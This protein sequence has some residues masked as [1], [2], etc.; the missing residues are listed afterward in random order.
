MTEM[1]VA[2]ND[3]E[4][5]DL[6]IEGKTIV[7][8]TWIRIVDVQIE[9]D[10][11]EIAKA[12]NI[13]KE[14]VR[15]KM[16]DDREMTDV[17]EM[18]DDREMIVV[19]LMID[20]RWIMS[21]MIG[22]MT[23]AADGCLLQ[24][25]V[26]SIAITVV[27]GEIVGVLKMTIGDHQ[28]RDVEI[29]QTVE[30]I[31]DLERNKIREVQMRVMAGPNP[32]DA[33][34]DDLRVVLLAMSRRISDIIRM[35]PVVVDNRMCR[36]V[37]PQMRSEICVHRDQMLT[38]WRIVSTMDHDR[39]SADCWRRMRQH[40]RGGFWRSAYYPMIHSRIW[41]CSMKLGARFETK[42]A[43][44]HCKALSRMLLIS[45]RDIAVTR[46]HR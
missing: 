45:S 1:M 5:G 32:V 20:L 39:R 27:P 26:V 23:E 16:T 40:L 29:E 9:E 4:G 11:L 38:R 46:T 12:D 19:Q 30:G 44:N 25:T 3:R 35:D 36:D 43:A 41:R 31:C 21:V 42:C 13:E 28:E 24:M 37:D 33:V 15:C 6:M 18:I 7:I 2:D 17:R 22:L 34:S 10:I 8:S 14:T